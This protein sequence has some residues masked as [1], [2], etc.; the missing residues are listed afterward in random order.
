MSKRAPRYKAE[1]IDA[2][3][4]VWWEVLVRDL[5]LHTKL[6]ADLH[7]AGYEIRRASTP[8]SSKYKVNYS[9]L[10]PENSIIAA[11]EAEDRR[12]TYTGNVLKLLLSRPGHWFSKGDLRRVGGDEGPKRF[13]ELRGAN[14]PVETRPTP[15]RE[16]T[17]Q[18]R[19]IMETAAR[20]G[21]QGT[22]F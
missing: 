14:W 11:M 7:A 19:I 21:E 1:V 5:P 16:S 8:S 18:Y 10:D 20:P 13:R 17:W 15:G 22:M 9:H 6:L 3:G 4:T 2:D 12:E